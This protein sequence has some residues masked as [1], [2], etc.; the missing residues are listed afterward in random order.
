M[1]V[2]KFDVRIH[3]NIE[4]FEFAN[5]NDFD[6]N[7]I[8]FDKIFDI[9]IEIV[10]HNDTKNDTK[11]FVVFVVID[12]FLTILSKTISFEHFEHFSFSFEKI[13]EIIDFEYDSQRCKNDC[14]DI[15]ECNVNDHYC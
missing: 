2:F 8:N 9:V 4:F 1:N 3:E 13:V 6:S 12:E 11:K 10:V 14:R 15:D 5:E 7:F